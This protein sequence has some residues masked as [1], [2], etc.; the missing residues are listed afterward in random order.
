MKIAE[1][2]ELALSEEGK[3]HSHSTKRK[4]ARQTS[5]SVA[6]VNAIIRKDLR[7]KCFKKSKAQQLTS[8]NKLAHCNTLMTSQLPND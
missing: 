5:I 8:D 3:P 7:F 1:V 2:E 4:I 6:S